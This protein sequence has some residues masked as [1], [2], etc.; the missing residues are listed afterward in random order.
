MSDDLFF[1][2][3]ADAGRLRVIDDGK[4]VIQHEILFEPSVNT[5]ASQHLFMGRNYR[6]GR[7]MVVFVI[8]CLS[9]VGLLARAVWMQAVQGNYYLALAENNRLRQTPIL[10]RRGM[11]RDRQGVILADNVSRFQVTLTPRD[12]AA[13][14][15]ER[16]LE[17]GE[18]TRL[19]GISVNDVEPLVSATG[20]AQDE[21]T[22]ITNHVPYE[23]AMAFAVA[24]PHLPGLDLQVGAER[25]YPQSKNLPSL[26]HILGYVGK[27]SAEEYETLKDK[28]Y[29]RANEI[30]KAGIERSYEQA[31]R[32]TP[33]KRVSE[34]DAHGAV[35]ALVGDRPAVDGKDLTLTIDRALQQSAETALRDG[36]KQAHVRRGAAIVMDPKDGGLLAVVSLP[37]YDDN[38]FSGG[39]SSTAFEALI[40]NSDQ[41]LFPRAWAGTYPSGSTV[42]I[43]ISAAA[44]AEKVITAKTTVNSTGGIKVGP[45]FFPD[46][47]AGGHGLTNVRKAIAWSVNSFYY[48]IGGGYESFIGLGVDR[49]TEWMRKFGLGSKTGVDLPGEGAGFVPSQDWKQRT[50][51]ERWFV[52]DTYNLSIGQGDLLVTPLQVA[53]YTSAIANGGNKITPHLLSA[54]GFGP[55]TT[56]IKYPSQTISGMNADA[57]QTVRLGMRDAVSYGSARGLNDLPFNVAA[58]TGTAQWSATKATH[59]WITTYAPADNPEIVVTV[60]LEEGGEGSSTALPVAHRIL[61]AWWDLKRAL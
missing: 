28:D 16:E 33:G 23:Q 47:K 9:F 6:K 2:P 40:G 5:L 41:P 20:T 29:R 52:G 46:W 22:V 57:V 19:L 8:L 55:A 18:A 37:A 38:I 4:H 1:T 48:T 26:S 25:R 49:L 12:L 54:F 15:S 7:F 21:E 50:K 36:M 31:L 53:A 11:I 59:A 10:P 43:V 60:L 32:G 44:L 24:L 17:I 51:G 34:V 56:L 3:D 35:K 39:V 58:K 61:Q 27:L 30:G 14:Q 13:D 42:K 45:W